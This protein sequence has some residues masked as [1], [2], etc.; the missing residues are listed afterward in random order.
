MRKKGFLE[1]FYRTNMYI[2]L[3]QVLWRVF[4]IYGALKLTMFI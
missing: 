2:K 1:D 4:Y 3:T